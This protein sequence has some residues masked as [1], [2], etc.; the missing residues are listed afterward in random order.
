MLNV[1]PDQIDAMKANT[2]AFM[3]FSNI[4]ISSAERLT[5]L[6][7]NAARAVLEESVAASGS[8]L[9]SNGLTIPAKAKKAIPEA[10]TRNALAYFQNVQDIARE[11][12]Q[13]VTKLMTSYFAS[14]GNGSKYSAGWLNGFGALKSLAGQMTA[15]T[16]AN[17]KAM[18]DVTSRVA[19]ATGSH[20]T[21][22][23]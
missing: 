1:I 7:L 22:R 8:M 18:T 4:A 14:Q 20:S 19:S 3:A 21:R 12:Q 16:D 15:M 13:E 23:A 6:N 17:R 10:A 5:T 9:A 2:D 11:T